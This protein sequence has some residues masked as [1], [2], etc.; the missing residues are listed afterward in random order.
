M[1][2]T[3]SPYPPNPSMPAVSLPLGQFVAH[4]LQGKQLVLDLRDGQALGVVRVVI[5]GLGHLLLAIDEILVVIEVPV[6]RRDAVVA[7]Q[8]LGVGH[9]L[10]GQQGLVELFAVAGADDLD[11]VVRSK[12]LAYGQ[13]QVADGRGRRLLHKGVALL[14]VGEGVEHQVHRIVDGHEEPGHVRVGDGQR[15]AFL[16]QLDE[17][18]DDR[19]ARG[20]DVAVAGAAQGGAGR[21]DKT[22]LG[23]HQLF[24]QR[25]GDA[26][27]IDGV[28]R[29]VRAQADHL[30]HAADH[31]RVE[32]VLRAQHIGLHRLQRVE[33][34]GRHLL[35]RRRLE[36]VVHALH[37]RGDTGR[38]AHIADVELQL[39]IGQAD[40]HVLLFL[41]IPTEHPDFLDIRG[42]EAVE[43]SV[44]EGTGTTGD[45]QGFASEH[46]K[47]LEK[48]NTVMK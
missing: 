40:A 11:L 22:G 37:G 35:E 36:D 17:Q 5:L 3:H 20:H 2:L 10:A 46:Y 39:G 45:E 30:F 43:N 23:H 44:A 31:G 27:G 4:Q 21:V 33:L 18:R 15:L 48:T 34:A 28:D 41:F 14:G 29:L 24:H 6:V 19:P 32:H 25:L 13:G 42:Q 7:A 26:H 9:L 47:L 16:D 8:V 1:L 38:V 12:Q